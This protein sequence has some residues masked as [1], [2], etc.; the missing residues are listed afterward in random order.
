MRN[1]AMFFLLIALPTMQGCIGCGANKEVMQ[2]DPFIET[3]TEEERVRNK[4][5]AEDERM[6]RIAAEVYNM[7]E[8]EKKKANPPAEKHE[9][10]TKMK[11]GIAPPTQKAFAVESSDATK[12]LIVLVANE[13][14]LIETNSRVFGHIRALSIIEGADRWELKVK[15][16]YNFNE[17]L[18]YLKSFDK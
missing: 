1:I 12:R 2:N 8:A 4:I 3:E 10:E 13:A 14:K 5:A 11:A 9:S 6:R 17:V 16:T 18:E 15:A 7:M